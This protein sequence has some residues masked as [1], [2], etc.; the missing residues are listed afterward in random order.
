MLGVTLFGIFLTPVFF[1]TIDWLG[2]TPLF[3]SRL[4]HHVGRFSLDMLTLRPVRKLA[5]R[6]RGPHQPPQRKPA[7]APAPK[8][9]PAL[10]E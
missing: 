10:R 5:G 1:F 8:S 7:T 9:E 2:G 4:M 6:V 3:A